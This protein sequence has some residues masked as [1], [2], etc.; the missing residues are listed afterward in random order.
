MAL[1]ML[2]PDMPPMHKGERH[3]I[4]Q[5]GDREWPRLNIIVPDYLNA[6]VGTVART[7][8]GTWHGQ[9]RASPDA[10]GE[11]AGGECSQKEVWAR[12]PTFFLVK[13]F[14][15]VHRMLAAPLGACGD[16]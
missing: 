4:D 3:A 14:Q 9:R 16:K 15:V 11:G 5:F 13:E 6:D 7:S 2:D 8:V 1:D 10:I 12:C